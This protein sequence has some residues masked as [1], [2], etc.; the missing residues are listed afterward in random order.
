[1][2]SKIAVCDSGVGGVAVLKKIAN[3]FPQK[4]YIYIC[5]RA[6]MPYGNKTTGEILNLCKKNLKVAIEL[7]ADLLVIACNTMSE[8]GEQVFTNNTKI[9]VL[10]V[11]QNVRTIL[12][13]DIKSSLL[14][15]TQATANTPVCKSL[16]KLCSSLIKSQPNLAYE[17]EKNA[18]KLRYFKPNCLKGSNTKITRVFLGCTH[19]ILIADK[20]KNC[21]VN[22][23]VYDGT[24]ELMTNLGYLIKE[25]QKN[26]TTTKNC[27]INCND[28]SFLPV[29]KRLF[30]YLDN[31]QK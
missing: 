8:I 23:T 9:P 12:K 2:I 16:N 18:L 24:E 27:C 1:M 14:F 4:D 17:I 30:E 5:D 28:F 6:N 13:G 15:C 7:G 10:F 29:I 31:C 26:L 25:N 22:A 20:F 21:F 11:R 19:Y 3:A